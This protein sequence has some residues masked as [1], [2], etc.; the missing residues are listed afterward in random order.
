MRRQHEKRLFSNSESSVFLYYNV[1][2][3]MPRPPVLRISDAAAGF[4][5]T[6]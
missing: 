3:F 6:G 2:F 1:L 5:G 4:H